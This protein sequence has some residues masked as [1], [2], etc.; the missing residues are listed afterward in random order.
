MEQQH[1]FLNLHL[2]DLPYFRALLRAV[3]ARFYQ[4]IDLP[5]PTLDVGCGDGHF[6]SLTFDRKLEVG[7][8]PWAAP[9]V[10]ARERSVY[11]LLVRADGGISPFAD[12]TFNSAVSNS[13]LEHIPQVQDVI[14][15]VARLLKPGGIFVFCVPNHQ[16]DPGLSIGRYLHKLHLN[17]LAAGYLGFFDKITRHVH[18]DAP[19]E[20]QR[21][22]EK[23]GFEVERHW[24]YFPP[25]ALKVMEWGHYYGLPSWIIKKI[26][27]RWLLVSSRWNLF[28]QGQWLKKYYEQS[29]EDETGVC[30]FFIA[31][32]ISP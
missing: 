13:V 17:R 2:R 28:F 8:D 30:T 9:L 11:Q 32:R 26:T 12:K 25:S 27:G 23:S 4:D 15:E 5:A 22:L 1:D 7:M 20:W 14:D 16:F 24:N 18:L 3:E 31:R 21:R 6:A 29:G 19:E 10:E